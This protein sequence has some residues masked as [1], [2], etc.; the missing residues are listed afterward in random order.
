MAAEIPQAFRPS[1]A[2]PLR[3]QVPLLHASHQTQH[4]PMDATMVFLHG[5]SVPDDL[6]SDPFVECSPSLESY[7][8]VLNE[9]S[10]VS[11]E[12]VDKDIGFTLGHT[13]SYKEKQGSLGA[14]SLHGGT[15]RQL[16]PLT[17]LKPSCRSARSTRLA[18]SACNMKTLP[19]QKQQ[20]HRM[21][22]LVENGPAR[23]RPRDVQLK[24]A[25]WQYQSF[26]FGDF[27]RWCLHKYSGDGRQE[28]GRWTCSCGA[29]L[30]RPL[31]ALT[32]GSFCITIDSKHLLHMTKSFL[33]VVEATLKCEKQRMAVLPKQ[34][35][36]TILKRKWP[37]SSA[38]I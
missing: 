13:I 28:L 16:K 5:S 37:T 32:G 36:K 21:A 9:W 19:P 22:K 33:R 30:T 29:Q 35:V 11:E 4:L 17:N 12:P 7:G 15:K 25:R 20:W 24:I 14:G 6:P 31:I 18:I 27:C 38:S 3:T 2:R 8:T 10:S 23:L 26:A 34:S 1:Q